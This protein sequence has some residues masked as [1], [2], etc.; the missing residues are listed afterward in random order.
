MANFSDLLQYALADLQAGAM[1]TDLRIDELHRAAID[2]GYPHGPL[3]ESRRRDAAAFVGSGEPSTSAWFAEREAW[4]AEPPQDG[5]PYEVFLTLHDID[6][7]GQRI[8][9]WTIKVRSHKGRSALTIGPGITTFRRTEW[10]TRDRDYSRDVERALCRW[11]DAERTWHA[12]WKNPKQLRELTRN[13]KDSDAWDSLRKTINKQASEDRGQI[14][15]EERSGVLHYHLPT[16]IERLG[17]RFD[18][19]KIETVTSSRKAVTNR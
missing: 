12:T 13:P 17:H 10:Q 8:R 19:S 9:V 6:P 5:E 1:P 14:P 2:V 18:S 15:K 16:V 4:L 3:V 7:D 11:L